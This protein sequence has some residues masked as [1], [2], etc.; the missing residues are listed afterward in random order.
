[1][2]AVRIKCL[3]ITEQSIY[4]RI[5]NRLNCRSVHSNSRCFWY[6]YTSAIE[7]KLTKTSNFTAWWSITFDDVNTTTA[8]SIRIDVL[9]RCC[10]HRSN[11]IG[12]KFNWNQ[13]LSRHPTTTTEYAFAAGA[14]ANRSVMLFESTRSTSH[15]TVSHG[16]EFRNT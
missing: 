7:V 10:L 16:V 14:V 5:W 9:L 6:R 3:A 1:M 12:W 2:H 8:T 15:S 11:R 4:C 13:E